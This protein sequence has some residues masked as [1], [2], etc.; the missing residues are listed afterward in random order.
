[1]KIAELLDLYNVVNYVIDNEYNHF[2]ECL[3]YDVT[4]EISVE[5]FVENS[6]NDNDICHI[7]KD[8]VKSKKLLN[9]IVAE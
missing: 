4:G 7:Y 8:A 5:E 9:S 2:L 6:V 3:D 1:M